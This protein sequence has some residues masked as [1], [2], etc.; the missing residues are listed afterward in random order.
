MPMSIAGIPDCI[1]KTAH[2]RLLYLLDDCDN[3][4]ECAWLTDSLSVALHRELRADNYFL[5]VSTC[6]ELVEV[7]IKEH[8]ATC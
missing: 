8:H 5:D 7:Y 6:K 3:M 1:K 4:E 2:R